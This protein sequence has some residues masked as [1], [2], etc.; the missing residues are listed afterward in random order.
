LARILLIDDEPAI[1]TVV[2]RMLEGAGHEFLE[3][4]E[5]EAGMRMLAEHRPDLVITDLFMP[6]QDGIVTVRRIRKE[7]P[8]VKVIVVSGG[9]STGRLD[10]RKEAEMLGA[11]ASLRKPFA[12]ADLLRVIR[13]ALALPEK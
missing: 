10:L 7:F 11:M 4:S 13:E 12:A 8:S 1:R 3:A 2:R 9:D 5:G 6:G